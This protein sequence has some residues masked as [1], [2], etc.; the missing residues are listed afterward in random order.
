VVKKAGAR[1]GVTIRDLLEAGLH[2]GH[3]TKR[4]NPKMKRF[5]FDERNGIYIIDLAKSLVQLKEAQEFLRDTVLRGRSVL[6]VGTKKQAQEPL[7]EA[8]EHLNQH[9]V[10]TR[11]LGG[12]LTNNRTIRQSVN[13]MRQLETME[14][15]GAMAALPKKEQA[16]LRRE[17]QKLHRNL[18]GIANMS[19]LPGALF[20]VDVT[21]ESIAVAEANRLKIPV[22]AMIDTNCDPDPI[23]HPIP[24][25]DDAIRAIRLVVKVISDTIQDASNEYAKVAAER[26]KKKAAEEAEAAAKAKVEEEER[27]KKEEEAKKAR[28]EAIEKAKAEKAEEKKEAPTAEAK[29]KPKAKAQPKPKAEE[30]AK[31]E[32]APKAEEKPAEPKAEKPAG[33]AEPTEAAPAS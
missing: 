1:P 30:K 29:E 11:W 3:Q 24:G 6:F 16:S 26:A 27:K 15:N 9:Y 19:E 17:H 4:W 20:V 2:F 5:I 13:R 18:C 10:T 8:A 21:R 23:D 32:P 22:V 31:S 14:Q 33:E 28:A 12:T 25:N 7:K